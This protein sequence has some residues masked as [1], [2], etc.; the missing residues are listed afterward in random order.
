MPASLSN[1]PNQVFNVN[2][3][4]VFSRSEIRKSIIP[5]ETAQP[6]FHTD[7]SRIHTFISVSKGLGTFYF[8]G[9][10]IEV[11]RIKPKNPGL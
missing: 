1:G 10:H 11:I 9:A 8:G 6:V 2:I 5:D 3:T 4:Q 7:S